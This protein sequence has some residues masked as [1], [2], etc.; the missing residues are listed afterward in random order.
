MHIMY[1]DYLGSLFEF[2]SDSFHAKLSRFDSLRG[3]LDC[4]KLLLQ[5]LFCLPVGLLFKL[6]VTFCRASLAFVE[7]KEN[8]KQKSAPSPEDLVQEEL[9]QKI[10]DR[11]LERL[12]LSL[13]AMHKDAKVRI[14]MTHYPPISADLKPSRASQ[15]LEEYGVQIAV[16]GHLHSLRANEPLFGERNGVRYILTSSDYIHFQPVAVL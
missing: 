7:F 14:A 10:F 5:K 16:F 1:Q 9:S 2:S 15:I 6:S 12:K 4:F 3:R 13:K 8:P 11:D